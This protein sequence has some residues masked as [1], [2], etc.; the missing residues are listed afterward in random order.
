MSVISESTLHELAEAKR[1]WL[2]MDV[3]YRD[4]AEAL[5]R[6]VLRMRQ[7][8]AMERDQLLR[9]ISELMRQPADT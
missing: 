6:E 2:S 9:I 7:A 4:L 8:H 1:T 3:G 5:A